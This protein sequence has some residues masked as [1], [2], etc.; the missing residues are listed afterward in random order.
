M[1]K[2]NNCLSKHISREGLYHLMVILLLHIGFN[3]TMT[4][5][6]V[7]MSKVIL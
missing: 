2:C 1:I 6:G 3:L 7:I 5:A 4:S